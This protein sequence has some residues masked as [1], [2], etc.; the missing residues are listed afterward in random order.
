MDVY[1]KAVVITEGQTE[2]FFF[3]P[4]RGSSQ[5]VRG[6]IQSLHEIGGNIGRSQFRKLILNVFNLLKYL[7]AALF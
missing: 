4:S 6:Q 7:R 1:D 5:N 3:Y 2:R